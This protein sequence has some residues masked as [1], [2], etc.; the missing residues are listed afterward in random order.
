MSNECNLDYNQIFTK[1]LFQTLGQLVAGLLSSSLVIPVYS[2]YT[3]GYIF[4]NNNNNNN[5]TNNNNN[6]NNNNNVSQFNQPT[7][8]EADNEADNED[9]NTVSDNEA[10]DETSDNEADDETSENEREQQAI[11]VDRLLMR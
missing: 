6:N 9:D 1:Q 2:F 11:I 10:D 5:N 8:N 7:D 4:Y 3:R